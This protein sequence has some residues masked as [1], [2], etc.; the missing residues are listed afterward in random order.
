LAIPDSG[1]S[2]K[3]SRFKFKFPD[4]FMGW[5]AVLGGGLLAL[6]GYGYNTYGISAMFKPISEELG[7][8]RADTSVASSIG[9]LE[10]GIEGPITGWITDRFGARWV[11]FSG[12]FLISLSLILMSMVNSLWSFYLVWGVMLGTGC[13]IALTLPIDT[14]ISNWFVKKRG[15]ALSIKWIFS[16]I[17]GVAIMP[18]IAWL[19]TTYNWRIACTFGGIVM[20]VVGLPIAWFCFRPHRPEYYGLLP[21]GARVKLPEKQDRQAMIEKG[22]EYA[23]EIK[24]VEFTAKQAIKT[25]TFWL[26]IVV[27]AVH[28]LVAPVMSIHCI[29]FLTDRGID[30]LKAAAIM[31]IWITASL[32]TR[33]I[34]GLV[35]DR[36][37]INQLRFITA[38]AYFLE[39]VGVIIFLKYPTDTMI[40]AWFIL[41]G[42]G[43][44]LI[45]TAQ[46]LIRA[47]YFGR[48][49]FGSIQGI[50]QLIQTPVGVVAPIY[51]GWV[52]DTT[53]SYMS[54]FAQFAVLLAVATVLA[55]FIFPPKPPEKITDIGQIF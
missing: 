9:R 31:S 23:S 53:G 4:I 47:R 21:D 33:F 39:A 26:M 49:A 25:R 52:Y 10:G 35:A 32:P 19:T 51:A 50:S 27:Q 15:V 7:F 6:W 30:P 16:G 29:P 1:G 36:L 34:G 43:Q 12:V 37:K 40:Y 55:I 17:S 3:Q 41:Y 45:N 11:V 5:W 46:P 38:A 24:E 44:G 14:T 2:A 28:G 48:K 54:A 22:Q 13:N 20:A 8:S 42:F 18:M